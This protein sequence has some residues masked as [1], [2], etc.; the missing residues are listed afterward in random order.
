MALNDM[1]F[2]TKTKESYSLP[3]EVHYRTGFTKV[4]VRQLVQ[5]LKNESLLLMAHV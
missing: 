4:A 2:S 3:C 5:L 1:P